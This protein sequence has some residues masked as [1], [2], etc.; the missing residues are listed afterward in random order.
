[1]RSIFVGALPKEL[2]SSHLFPMNYANLSS[3]S[4]QTEK[5]KLGF[6]A[7]AVIEI[8]RKMEQLVGRNSRTAL[9]IITQKQKT[10]L[11]LLLLEL[12]RL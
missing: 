11:H 6:A 10:P 9:K 8:R 2:G 12:G 3:S 1:V 5:T 7:E 4:A